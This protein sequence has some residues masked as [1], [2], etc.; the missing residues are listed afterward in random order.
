ML[1]TRI[2]TEIFKQTDTPVL[3]I[4]DNSPEWHNES[5]AALPAD[6]RDQLIKYATRGDDIPLLLAGFRFDRL[7]AKQHLLLVGTPAGRN[8]HEKQLVRRLIPTLAEGGDPWLATASVIGPLLDWHHCAA[9][10]HKSASADDLLGHWHDGELLPPKHL[11]LE[12]SAAAELYSEEQEQLVLIEPEKLYPNDPLFQGSGA[13]LCVLQRV[14]RDSGQATGYLC[15]W[16]ENTAQ[17]PVSAG[18]VLA[19]A[20]DL[21]ASHL[22]AN[23]HDSSGELPELPDYPTDDLT[24]LPGRTAFDATLELFEEHYRR[25][26]QSCELA[27]L[28][29]N[30]LS[31]INQRSGIEK[32]DEVL[33]RFAN[34]LRHICRPEDRVFRFGGDEFVILMPY[35]LEPPP[36]RER[37]NHVEQEMRKLP[38][39]EN[40]SASSGI[41]SIEETNGS[42]DDLMLLS[43]RRLRQ[44]KAARNDNQGTDNG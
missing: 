3:L 33:C 29:I 32:G 21:L 42:S 44:A 1:K 43:D 34:L 38:G 36:L 9:V 20:A 28:D 24:G 23:G 39:L 13:K 30:G 7:Q 37:L 8:L 26:Q 6:I 15:L 27:M 11:P 22:A 4:T 12:S 18:R 19:L 35:R 2:I 40:F 16:S 31:A 25:Y 14:D 10:K 5:F 41:A 17:D